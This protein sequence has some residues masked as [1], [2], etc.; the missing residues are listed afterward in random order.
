VLV[1]E[2][3]ARWPAVGRQRLGQDAEL[4]LKFVRQIDRLAQMERRPPPPKVGGGE[5]K[6]G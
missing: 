6:G 5:E 2:G 3:L 4:Y 1:R